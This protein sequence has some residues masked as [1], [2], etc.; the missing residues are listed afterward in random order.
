MRP[1]PAASVCSSLQNAVFMGDEIVASPNGLAQIKFI[2]KTRIVIGPNS[3]LKIDTFV[4]Q[5]R[6]DRAKK[7]VINMLE[8]IVSL[9]QRQQPGRRLHDPHADR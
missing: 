3:R 4:L 9:H 8:G 1:D 2:D 6:S 5:S 7:V